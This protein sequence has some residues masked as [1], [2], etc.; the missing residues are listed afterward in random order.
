MQ[1][2]LNKLDGLYIRIRINNNGIVHNDTKSFIN[3]YRCQFSCI[4]QQC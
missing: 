4:S 1:K 3:I 2:R